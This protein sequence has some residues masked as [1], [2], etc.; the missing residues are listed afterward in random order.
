MHLKNKAFPP[1][2]YVNPKT[3]RLKR[4]FFAHLQAIEI[5][6]EHPNVLLMDYTYK[7]SQF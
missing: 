6:K 4:L 5:Y 3:K 1:K 2:K 7:T